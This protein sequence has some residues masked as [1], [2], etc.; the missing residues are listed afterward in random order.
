MTIETDLNQSPYHDDFDPSNNY[1]RILF[2]PGYG[3]QARELTQ[4]QSILQGQISK[5]AEDILVDGTVI[6]GVGLT[7]EPVQYIKL[8]DVDTNSRALLAS[9]FEDANNNIH[10]L[11][12]TG[13]ETGLKAT[14]VS[15]IDG[16]ETSGS[17]PITAYVRY[18]NS[19]SNNTTKQF[20]DDENLTFAWTSNN[21]TKFLGTTVNSNSTGEG[22]KGNVIDGVVYHKGNFVEVAPQSIIVGKYTKTPTKRVGLRTIETIIDSNQDSSLLDNATGSSNYSAPG[23]N[24]LKLTPTLAIEN[25]SESTANFFPLATIT[26][27]AIE[28]LN[29]KTVYSEIGDYIAERFH[30]T[31]GNYVIEPFDVRIREHL[32]TSNN[33]GRFSSTD[34]GN[35]SLLVAEVEKGKGYV[36]GHQIELIGADYINIEKANESTTK[37]DVVIGQTYGNYIIVNDVVGPYDFANLTTMSLRDAPQN[38]ISTS[39]YSRGTG[40]GSNIGSARV[41][42]IQWESGAPGTAD[43]RYRIYIF[44]IKMNA[45]KSFSE[46]KSIAHNTNDSYADVILENNVAKLKESNLNTFVFPTGV[47]GTKTLSNTQFVVRKRAGEVAINTNGEGTITTGNTHPGGA[48]T[49]KDVGNPLSNA[50]ERNYIIVSKT[51]TTSTPKLGNIIRLSSDGAVFGSGT[52]FTNDYKVGD[53]I[54]FTNGSNTYIRT[55]SSITGDTFMRIKQGTNADNYSDF[56]NVSLEHKLSFP[57]GYIWDLET[58][59]TLSGSGSSINLNVGRGSLSSSF[60]AEIYYDVLRTSAS[61]ARKTVYKNKFVKINT[62]T[63]TA[64]GAGPWSLGVSDAWK[65]VSVSDG[66]EDVTSK[67]VLDTGAKDDFYDTSFLKLKEGG[68]HNSSN[69]VVEFNY[70]GRNESNGYGFL[71]A[72]SYADI[73]DDDDPNGDNNISTQEI[74]IFVS[75]K[76][77]RRYDLR[78]SIDFRPKK[79]NDVVPANSKTSITATHTNPDILT[80]FDLNSDYGLYVPTP[81]QEFQTDVEYYLPRKDLIVVNKAGDFEQIK[82][83][84]GA[85]PRTPA[86]PAQSMTI[87]SI[88]IPPYPSLSPYV[89]REYDRP[90]YQTEVKQEN[91]RRYT[92]SDIRALEERIRNVEYYSNLTNLETSASN[93]QLF[94]TAGMSRFKNG[95]F[96]DNFDGHQNADTSNPNYR[97]AIDVNKKYLRPTFNR[98]DIP[99]KVGSTIHSTHAVETGNLLTL[100][101][102]HAKL[103]DQKFASKLRNPVQELLFNWY[104]ECR[105]D[106]EADNTPSTTNLP[107]VQVDFNGINSSFQELAR[108]TGITTGLNFGAWRTTTGNVTSSSIVQQL[109]RTVS[110]TAISATRGETLD[111]GNLVTNVSLREYMRSIPI[112]I[113]AVRMKPNTKVFAFFDDEKVSDYCTPCDANFNETGEAGDALTTDASGTVYLLF[114]IPDDNTLKFRTGTKQFK[115]QDISNPVTESELV[116]TSAVGSF[117]SN[118]LDVQERGT[119][120]NMVLPQISTSSRVERRTIVRRTNTVDRSRDPIAQS[121]E[122]NVPE[123]DGTWITKLDLFFGRKPTGNNVSITLQIREMLNGLPTNTIVP[124]GSKTIKS[125][126]VNTSADASL[127]TTFTFD[128][129][130]YLENDK[131]YSFVVIPSG[132]NDDFALWS[133]ELGGINISDENLISKQP[134]TGIMFVS[135]NDNTWSPIMSEDLKFVLHRAQFDISSNGVVYIENSNNEFFTIKDQTKRFSMGE[136]IRGDSVL[137]LANTAAVSVGDSIYTSV[138]NGVVREI[139][140]GA[141][142]GQARVRVSAKGTFLA[143]ANV[144]LQTTDAKIA[145]VVSFV[146]NTSVGDSFYQDAEGDTLYL[147]SST[148][149]FGANT[150]ITGQSSGAIAK[151]ESIDNID[152]NLVVPKFPEIQYAKTNSSWTIRTTTDAGVI[153]SEFD[154]V[155]LGEDNEFRDGEKRIYST[156]N[157]SPL[158][159]VNGSKKSIIFKGTISSQND[160]VSP[161]IDTTRLNGIAIENIINGN[162]AG[163]Q[164][165]KGD[166]EVRYITRPIN[167]ADGQDAEDMVVYL[168][169]Y[170]PH[171]TDIKVYAR[172]INEED[173]Q[174][175]DEK[176]FSE[177]VQVNSSSVGNSVAIAEPFDFKE[178]E[179]TFAANTSGDEFLVAN[180]NNR[181]LLNTGNNNVVAYR[182]DTGGIFHSYKT[183]AL[184]IVMTSTGKEIIPVVKDLRAIALQK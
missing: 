141:S 151:I 174:N 103:I 12:I 21:E 102:S 115:L 53:V 55:I 45:G 40:A 156:S 84:P 139:L 4:I 91:N 38:A 44:D 112:K 182:S 49:L 11:T 51:A 25:I 20:N 72:D 110:S 131:F 52:S 37:E 8:K 88:S 152:Y 7:T 165:S 172:V 155:N 173:D 183:F 118:S 1:N 181:A 86:V 67:F 6:K 39:V 136:N 65:L 46:V 127:P 114:R 108:A 80:A 28:Q 74:P 19:G 76:N 100:P 64:G 148:G 179:Y 82:G 57:V 35:N 154:A 107:D 105:L 163:E 36:Q 70:F 171:G 175:F 109:E 134:A 18:I 121:F 26:D 2:R 98:F 97:A 160:A 143:S 180:T 83:T 144:H 147:K 145:D 16:T 85:N 61:P 73:V 170:K 94:N 149:S 150:Y 166:A 123:A 3:V 142:T 77:N 69:L 137:T 81:D 157:E 59:G 43:A 122:V 33:L 130:V 56:I 5:F 24:R 31:N 133:G 178:M 15:F 13:A 116:T 22:L 66:D 62:S 95:F 27:G 30:D 54:T 32:K 71:S 164:N 75:Q 161:V 92:M 111:L 93:K 135:S 78:D 14:L 113:T 128:S 41:R 42:G 34:S 90:D 167:L 104:G 146:A 126:A 129:P 132:N 96:V 99:F 153:S 162:T 140:T 168:N 124:Y 17:D 119:S 29:T 106:P 117:T 184:K 9:D 23:A 68:V 60:N 48:E 176:E 50:D 138:A 79:T 10:S 125:G 63:H 101:Y 89:A 47:N 177:L 58:R 158:S 120:I 87:A 159:A 169:A